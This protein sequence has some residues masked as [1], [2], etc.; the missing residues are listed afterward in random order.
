MIARTLAPGVY[1]LL[2]GID[3]DKPLALLQKAG[4]DIVARPMSGGASPDRAVIGGS[5]G[6]YG[7]AFQRTYFPSLHGNPTVPCAPETPSIYIEQ[8][9]QITRLKERF[10]L[11]LAKLSLSK[12]E[13]EELEAR[14]DRRL[15]LSE[16]QLS[17]ASVRYEK[18][19]A[20]GLDYVGKASLA[21]QAL[22]EKSLLELFLP[23]G[24]E[25]QSRVLGF[26]VALE[27]Q[28]GELVL[29]INPQSTFPQSKSPENTG[30]VRTESTPVQ[31][32]INVPLGKISL[33]RRIKTSI[34][35]D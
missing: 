31:E 11:A 33:L 2:P 27:K 9:E 35:G 19:E 17:G 16:A 4:V 20:R 8:T 13:R 6:G 3:M 14:I 34:F 12:E 29:V 5:T 25:E 10:S 7:Q 32:N 26:P 22:A 28:S 24:D 21:R 30:K 18:M 1:V 15:I 23:Q